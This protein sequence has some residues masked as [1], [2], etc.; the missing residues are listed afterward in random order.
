MIRIWLYSIASFFSLAVLMAVHHHSGVPEDFMGESVGLLIILLSCQICVHVNGIDELLLNS[1]PEMQFPTILKSAGVAL[2]TAVIFFKLFSKLSPGYAAAAASAGCF[3]FGAIA[4][5]PIVRT[6]T[7]RR[8]G[9]ETL[10]LGSDSRARK[11]YAELMDDE[12]SG[13][14]RVI[15]YGELERF[16]GQEG[17]SRIVVADRGTGS[18]GTAQALIDFKLRGVKIETAVESFEKKSQKIWL[19]GLSPEWFIFAD[20]FNPSKLCL[21]CKRILDVTLSAA[22]LLFAGPLMALIAALIKL[23]SPGPAI[24]KQERV[25]LLGNRFIVF[26]FRTMRQDAETH[27]GP[28][29]AKEGDDRITR[30]GAFLRKCRLDELP[31]VINVL[32]GEMSF[33][34]PRPERPYFVELLKNKV[35]YYDLRHYAKPGITGWAQ[36]M[37]RYGASVEDAYNK[38][39]Y[40]LFYAKNISFRLDLLILFKTI[41]VVF[42]GEG[43]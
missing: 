12:K 15:P 17:V 43:R 22:L 39:Q 10:I 24:F 8:E 18:P 35:P 41:K 14:V 20:G 34:G 33:I 37:Y 1:K 23:D 27:S 2:I 32:R 19:E 9:E 11:L 3:M 6:R 16:A 5:R 40:D 4:V 21:A 36:V 42:A 13:S 26:K 28:I 7:R 38:L 31:Q 29:W 25:G 30:L